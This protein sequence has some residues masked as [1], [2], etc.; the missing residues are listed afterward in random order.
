M[1]EKEYKKSLRQFHKHSDR[2]IL[3]VETDMSFS[4]IQKVVALSDKIRKAGNELVGLMRKNYDQLIRTK[5]YRKVRKLYGATEEKKKRKV[6]ARQLNEMQKQYHVTW[7][8]CRTSMIPIGK[9]YGI[10]AIFAL[11]GGLF[12]KTQRTYV[13]L[14]DETLKRL[15]LIATRYGVTR[16]ALISMVLGQ[17]CEST[18]SLFK[19]MPESLTN[20]FN[21]AVQS[22]AVDR[23]PR[24]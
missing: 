21:A 1:N 16:S 15:D 10:D 20:A 24:G 2:H 17:Y 9:K 11:G 12:M 22:G 19:A 7:D 3:V 8:D 4:D 13:S 14:S 6:L 18:E 5:R 23:L